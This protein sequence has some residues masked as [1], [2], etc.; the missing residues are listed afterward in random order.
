MLEKATVGFSL[1]KKLLG[2]TPGNTLEGRVETFLRSRPGWD[3]QKKGV[4]LFLAQL[5]KCRT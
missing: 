4:K 2:K 1:S 5:Y 3:V